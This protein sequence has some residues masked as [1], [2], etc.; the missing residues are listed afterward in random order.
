M[1]KTDGLSLTFG[2]L[3]DPT[4]RAILA[5]LSTGAL[6]VNEVAEP[7]AMTLGAVSKH[8]KVLEN[9]GLI[10]RERKSQWRPCK[11]DAGP[12]REAVI[13]LSAYRD[14]W[15]TKFQ[16]LDD[17]L[18]DLKREDAASGMAENDKET[19]RDS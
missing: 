7:F 17:V 11:L 9:A 16:R 12:M 1:A 4:R 19:D 15:E 3:A 10:A 5:R 6:T 14:Q 13:W 8:L 2:A 18:E